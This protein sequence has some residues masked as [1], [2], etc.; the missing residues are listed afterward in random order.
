MT[1]TKPTLY[2]Q[3]SQVSHALLMLTLAHDRS[4]AGIKALLQ[5]DG[6]SLDHYRLLVQLKAQGGQNVGSLRSRMGGSNQ[7][8][9]RL[10]TRLFSKALIH[11][12]DGQDDRRQRHIWLTDAGA[13]YYDHITAAAR[14]RLKYAFRD[15]EPIDVGGFLAL[16]GRL[17]P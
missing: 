13:A 10:L 17:Q 16:L 9:H 6:F 14:E 1:S 5:A 7:A 12:T 3:D 2:L 11:A 4:M 15:A 8:L